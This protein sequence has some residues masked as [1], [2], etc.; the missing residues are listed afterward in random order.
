M[1]VDRS[2]KKWSV[3]GCTSRRGRRRRRRREKRESILLWNEKEKERAV[4]SWQISDILCYTSTR[5]RIYIAIRDKWSMDTWSSL[6]HTWV[7]WIISRCCVTIDDKQIDICTLSLYVLSREEEEEEE[8]GGM[9]LTCEAETKRSRVKQNDQ[10]TRCEYK[11]DSDISFHLCQG[12]FDD[13]FHSSQHDVNDRYCLLPPL[14]LS[15]SMF[16]SSLATH[17]QYIAKVTYN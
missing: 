1:K 2:H 5:L 17:T 10:N 13:A 16:A 9:Y 4:G 7:A 14:S 6:I 15:S 11:L 8:G 3:G 12:V